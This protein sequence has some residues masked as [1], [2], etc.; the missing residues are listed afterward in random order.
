MAGQNQ[1]ASPGVSVATV[2]PP[3]LDEGVGAQLSQDL[4]GNQRVIPAKTDDDLSRQTDLETWQIAVLDELRAIRI[5]MQFLVRNDPMLVDTS[6]LDLL[7]EAQG[8]RE[9]KLEEDQ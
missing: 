5:G 3:T 2:L 4:K 9:T 6:A 7:A 8:V 1:Y